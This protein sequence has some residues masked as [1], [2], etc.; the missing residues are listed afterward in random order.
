LI[1][2]YVRIKDKVAWQCNG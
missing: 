1:E 2:K